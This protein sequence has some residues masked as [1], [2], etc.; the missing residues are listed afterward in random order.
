MMNYRNL[1]KSD[2]KVSPINL[3]GNVFGWTLNEQES[4]NILDAFADAGFNFIDTADMYSTWLPGNIGGESESIIGK[5]MKLKG[6]RSNLI[7]ATKLGAD[8]GNGKAGLSAKY[9]KQAVEDS[10]K[11]LKTDYIDLYISHYDDPSTSIEETITAFNNLIKEGKVR[12]I[13]ASNLSPERIKS[14]IEFASNNN[15]KEYI[16]IQ[17]LYNLYDR[18]TFEQSYLPLAEDYNL[19][20]T[21]YY[22]LASG[23]L[24]G[25]YRSEADLHKSSRGQG[26]KRYLDDR[27][28]KI[29]SA[30]DKISD[31]INIPLSQIAIAWQLHKPFITS[32]IASATTIDQLNNIVAS[33]TIKLNKEQLNQLDLA[34][35]Y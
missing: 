20:V 25:K 21:S 27:G 26:I 23:F 3:G 19:A 6:N 14:S 32:P 9:I 33:T 5:W 17:P 1:G 30:M 24:T 18:H 35:N 31:E 16:S 15:L 2:I 4:F 29:L 34:S 28:F 22:A 10:L 8:M 11:R 7:I 13:G 12:E